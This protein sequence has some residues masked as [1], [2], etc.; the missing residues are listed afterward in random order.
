MRRAHP[1]GTCRP[2]TIA[3]AV[4][5]CG[6]AC[7]A[8]ARAQAAPP[9]RCHDAVRVARTTLTLH[10]VDRAGLSR[11]TREELMREAPV[12]WREAGVEVRWA[13]DEGAATGGPEDLYVIV[14]RDVDA[15][16]RGAGRPLARPLASILFVD[17]Q[18]TT[19][20][21]AY[22]AE[23]ERLAAT[24][25][26]DDKPW[27][28]HPRFLR[29]RLIGRVL[30]RAVAHEVGHYLFA[31]ASHAPGGLMRARHPIERLLTSSGAAF[32]VIPP[33]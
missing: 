20:V 8:P 15:G 14:T 1:P 18:P 32:Q 25:R 13:I 4:L 11:G 12:P 5:V 16:P 10:L 21:Q 33:P 26:V 30:G 24:V 7:A 19:Q 17:G 28:E 9:E 6:L 27:L 2:L 23:V 3:L 29:E 22:V 31:S